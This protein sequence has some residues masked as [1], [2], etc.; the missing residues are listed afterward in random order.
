MPGLVRKSW[1]PYQTAGLVRKS[2]FSLPD[3]RFGKEILIFLT[4]QPPWKG[5]L[6]FPYQTANLVRK[7]WFYL[8]DGWSGKEILIFLT[9]WGTGIHMLTILVRKIKI[10][11]PN[12]PSG[13]ENPDFL[14]K[15]AGCLVRKIKISL[16]NRA[17]G[18]EN[19]DFLTKPA[20]W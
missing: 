14:S 20:V 19:R 7:S 9:G 4:R 18:K 10:S 16:P 17:S 2:R 5:N 15:P 12:W 1:F 3:A 6:D 8:R 13:K 11:L